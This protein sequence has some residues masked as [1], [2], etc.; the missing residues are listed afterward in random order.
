MNEDQNIFLHRKL[1]HQHITTIITV[2]Y[3]GALECDD[4]FESIRNELEQLSP[5]L[6][7]RIAGCMNKLASLAEFV[8]TFLSGLNAARKVSDPT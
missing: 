6:L 8:D 5:E 2:L 7:D 1:V 4:A 3:P